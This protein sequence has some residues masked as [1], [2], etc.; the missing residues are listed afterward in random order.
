MES[1]ALWILLDRCNPDGTGQRVWR[2]QS[3]EIIKRLE[4]WNVRM[5]RFRLNFVLIILTCW[6]A[7]K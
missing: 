6:I 2:S 4:Q 3:S 5:E 7:S 1:L